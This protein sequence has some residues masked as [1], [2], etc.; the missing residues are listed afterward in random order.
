M[1]N[2]PTNNLMSKSLLN[3]S[4][5]KSKQQGVVLIVALVFLIALTAVAAALMQNT[6]TDIKMS[7][8]TQEK[9]IATQETISEMDRVIYNEIRR[10]NVNDAG[11]PINRF[12]LPA[13]SFV[14]P[15]VLTVTIP[16]RTVGTLDIANEFNLET[17]CPPTRSGSSTDVFTCNVLR[18]IVNRTYGRNNNSNVQVNSGV[19]QQLFKK[20]T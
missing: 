8:A 13:E 10:V 18:V 9:S 4:L 12:A 6:T 15:I 1:V 11:T 7:G 5:V 19:A 20:G 14:A 16:D 2:L 17:D 3:N